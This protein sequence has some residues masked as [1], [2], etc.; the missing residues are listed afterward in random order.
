MHHFIQ[1][2]FVIDGKRAIR[3]TPPKTGLSRNRALKFFFRE[4]EGELNNLYSQVRQMILF[5]DNDNIAT[6][7]LREI[8]YHE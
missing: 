6:I 3:E 2:L 1:L 7:H 4:V 5:E 8:P